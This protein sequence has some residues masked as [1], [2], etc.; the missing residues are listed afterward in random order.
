MKNFFWGLALIVAVFVP[1]IILG[2]RMAPERER[3]QQ[4]LIRKVVAEEMAKQ[5][6]ELSK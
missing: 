5:L 3:A 1:L 4:E 2:V 6:K